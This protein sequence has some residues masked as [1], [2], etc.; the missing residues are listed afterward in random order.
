MSTKRRILAGGA[1]ATAAVVLTACGSQGIYS[2]PLPGG[3]ALGA[4]PTVLHLQ[5]ANVLDLVPESSVRIGG[6]TVGKV[7]SIGIASDG[8]TAEVTVKVRDGV[9]VPADSRAQIEQS[10]LL[11]EKYITLVS[12]GGSD[13]QALA[14]GA[15][16]PAAQNKTTAGIEEVL[17]VLSLVL[18]DGGVGQLKPIV[19]E[20]NTAMSNPQQVRSLITQT[21]RLIEG[22][23]EQR[24]DITR[25][26]DGVA[27]L[28]R[29]AE[30]QTTQISRILA[31][32]P[33][34]A[35]VL[36]QQRPEIIEMVKQLDRLG[37]VG[38]DVLSRSQ[39]ETI[40]NL[41]ALRPTLRALAGA[42]D[43]IVTALP[44]VATF[45]FPDAGVDAIKGDSMNLFISLDTRLI[46]QLEALGA[47]KPAPVYV[48]PKYGPGSGRATGSSAS[49]Q[50]GAR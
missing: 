17:G 11:G 10:N 42:A 24:A 37:K 21:D 7:E 3:P 26:I 34:G 23:N 39:R 40:E 5:F 49:Q 25:A 47:G 50:G 20:L 33:R 8:W 28:S 2:L 31:E 48:P 41:L 15:T 13:G 27:A 44:F 22:L 43:D 16:I 36:N 6:A 45:P 46:N 18:N 38:T 1:L 4:R 35:A 14:S 12:S 29:R 9:K 30:A 19:D 32:L